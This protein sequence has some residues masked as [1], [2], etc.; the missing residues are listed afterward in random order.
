MI[1]QGVIL[2]SGLGSRLNKDGKS[3]PKPLMPV[4]GMPLI[5][6]IV[7]LM[8]RAGVEKIVIV[9]GFKKESIIDYFDKSGID[10]EF[11]ENE[12]YRKSNGISLLKA[13][14]KLDP[15]KPFLLSMSDHIF[16]NNFVE[17]LVSRGESALDN[18]DVLLGVDRAID[19]VFDL[20]DATKVFTEGPHISR[21]GKEL[22]AYNAIDTGIFI[23][24]H[25]IFELLDEV[26]S[27]KGDVSISDG[28]LRL[29]EDKRFGY[30]DMTG[31]LWQDVDTP[32]MKFEAEKRLLETV[33]EER[34]R[35]TIWEAFLGRISSAIMLSNLKRD[36]SLLPFLPHVS[37]ALFM[38]VLTLAMKFSL[39]Y[40]SILLYAA[41]ILAFDLE[42]IKR[43][44]SPS[45]LDNSPATER[46]RPLILALSIL[47]VILSA[48]AV[49]TVILVLLFTLVILMPLSKSIIGRPLPSVPV[50]IKKIFFNEGLFLLILPLLFAFR[51]PPVLIS[52]IFLSILFTSSLPEHRGE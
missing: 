24:R 11:V 36:T 34:N 52:L 23:C 42:A 13:A 6:R 17:K 33:V 28:M 50:K 22:K 30:V 4:G 32:S 8:K 3:E 10:V 25:R 27:K 15:E 39:P 44:L 18:F 41:A 35:D 26:Y 38:L 19:D 5:E 16:S 29:A 2:A 37:G 21:I 12:E 40:L 46:F 43:K 14:E 48:G 7:T 49:S 20:D 47:P 1:K 31:N 9:V 51:M 45:I